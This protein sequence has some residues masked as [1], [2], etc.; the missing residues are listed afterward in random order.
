MRFGFE[1]I[2]CLVNGGGSE[3]APPRL[4]SSD[5]VSNETGFPSSSDCCPYRTKCS[6]LSN[7]DVVVAGGG[8]CS[9]GTTPPFY[10]RHRSSLILT[11]FTQT[12][13]GTCLV[14]YESSY[15]G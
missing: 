2:E 3:A 10:S 4:C 12:V 5:S 11:V 15:T 13:S 6:G 9:A 8:D 1:V 14:Q 7:S